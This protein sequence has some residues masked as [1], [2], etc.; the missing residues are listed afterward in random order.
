[1]KHLFRK[2]RIL[3]GVIGFVL[4]YCGIS[5]SD[6]YALELGQ[7]E[8]DYVW[9]MINAGIML[10][11]PSFIHLIVKGMVGERYVQNR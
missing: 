2:T 5:T 8:P 7:A 11:I 4:I 3:M 1:M 9:N 6:Y 10:L